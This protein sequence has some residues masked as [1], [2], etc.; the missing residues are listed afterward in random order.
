MAE[1]ESGDAKKPWKKCFWGR[2]ETKVMKVK[3]STGDKIFLAVIYMLL[4]LAV[5]AVLYPLYIIVIA[6]VSDPYGD[7]GRSLLVAEG[8]FADWL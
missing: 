2:R 7:A 8:H 6:S 4:I 3:T 5:I 1:T